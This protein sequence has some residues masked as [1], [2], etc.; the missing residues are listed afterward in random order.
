VRQSKLVRWLAWSCPHNPICHK[1]SFEKLLGVIRDHRPEV[2]VCLGDLNDG[3]P[4]SRF[5]TEDEW[6][7][8]EEYEASGAH[9]RTAREAAEE[10]L[11]GRVRCVWLEGNHDANIT[12][13]NRLPKRLRSLCDWRSN[14]EL[15]LTREVMGGDDGPNWKVVP[16]SHR[17]V[18]RLGQVAFQHGAEHGVNAGR[19]LAA[20]YATENGLLVFGHT[21]RPL[22]PTQAMVTSK[23]PLNKWYANAGCLVDWNKL[24]YISRTNIATWGH[25]VVIGEALC[26]GGRIRFGGKNWS[27]ETIVFDTAHGG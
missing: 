2:L 15:S 6:T 11:C 10:A 1:P 27:A 25:A 26:G 22:P 14:P 18:W 3:N 9:L 13:E 12:A 16:Y 7:L 24:S 21:H 19:N 8:M 23:V 17:Q 20:L 5:A 4:A